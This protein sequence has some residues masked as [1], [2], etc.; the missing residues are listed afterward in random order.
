[1]LGCEKGVGA[2]GTRTGMGEE[3]WPLVRMNL[4]KEISQCGEEYTTLLGGYQ[5]VEHIKRS[6]LGDRL[7]VVSE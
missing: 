5:Q 2:K 3:S 1:L 6:L 4:F 7:L